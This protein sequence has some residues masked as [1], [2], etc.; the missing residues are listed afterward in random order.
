MKRSASTHIVPMESSASF[1]IT[2][3]VPQMNAVPHRARCPKK[4]FLSFISVI[5]QNKTRFPGDVRRENFNGLAQ[6]F[7]MCG[8]AARSMSFFVLPESKLI[9]IRK[10]PPMG[11]IFVS[12]P[13]PK[14]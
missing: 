13:A 1:R 10:S 11:V 8:A 12:V 9:S 5:T 6:A 14:A 4:F 2:K 3:D 7:F